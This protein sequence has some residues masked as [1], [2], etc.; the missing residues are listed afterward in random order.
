MA[1][2]F[3]GNFY[4]TAAWVNCREEY[5]KKAGGLCERC[6][7]KGIIKTGEIVHHKKHIEPENL[8]NPEITLNF[9]NLELL[10]RDCHGEAHKSRKKR[11]KVEAD[12]TVTIRG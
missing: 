7:S 2:E 10:C 8:N 6:Y 5:K 4:Q 11:Y 1:R 3:V 9:D 12:G